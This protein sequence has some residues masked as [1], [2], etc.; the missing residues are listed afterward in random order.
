[1]HDHTDQFVSETARTYQWQ[2]ATSRANKITNHFMIQKS[3]Y[4]SRGNNN[5][6]NHIEWVQGMQHRD[7]GILNYIYFY[8][9]IFGII[10]GS[11]NS[12][13]LWRKKSKPHHF[14]L[15]LNKSKDSIKSRLLI[16]FQYDLKS[17]QYFYTKYSKKKPRIDIFNI[18]SL[19]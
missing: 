5:T 16:H 1:M 19:I 18:T 8:W 9:V 10:V 17:N 2:S 7:R 4:P 6:N 12:N 13:T 15:V 11:M 3:I 14:K